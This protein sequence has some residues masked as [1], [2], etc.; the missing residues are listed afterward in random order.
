[1]ELYTT[2]VINI[3]SDL[4]LSQQIHYIISRNISGIIHHGSTDLVNHDE[5]IF[6]VVKKLNIKKINYKYIYTTNDN[7]YLALFSNQTIFPNHLQFSFEEVL[8]EI[9]K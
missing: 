1:M 7:R 4:K 5:Y 9:V 2:G 6:S 8:R 3:N